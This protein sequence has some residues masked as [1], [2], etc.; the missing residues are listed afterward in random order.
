MASRLLL[1]I[2]LALA[3]LFA[4]SKPDVPI[5]DD[6]SYFLYRALYHF[7]KTAL[8]RDQGSIG[9]CVAVSHAGALDVE[10][11]VS[12]VKSGGGKFK[13]HSAESIYG[14][15]RN[16]AHGRASRSYA[17][18]SNGH[19][20]TRWLNQ[21]GGALYQEKYDGVDLSNYEVPRAKDWGATGNGGRSDGVNPL[22]PLDKEAA[23]NRV[24]G[25]AL[26]GDLEELDAA[27][28]H[29][30]PVTIC[31]GVGFNSPRDKDGFCAPRGSWPHC[32]FVVGKRNEGRKG[33]L[34][35]NSWGRYIRGDGENSTNKYKDQP[36]GS[37]YIEPSVMLRILRSGDSWALSINGFEGGEGTT[38][39]EWMLN[40][41]SVIPAYKM[42]EYVLTDYWEAVAESDALGKPLLVVFS[43]GDDSFLSH[44]IGEAGDDKAIIVKI[45][46][47]EEIKDHYGIHEKPEVIAHVRGR[48]LRI[49]ARSV[50]SISEVLR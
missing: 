37:F 15:A 10:E 26:V 13:K 50:D 2:L 39:P 35:Q 1:S 46:E 6:G 45:D 27:L 43:S 7:D 11:A 8:P 16:E 48:S 30:H 49:D 31:S 32:M 33:Y 44:V 4:G 22:G 25:V 20:A 29:G 5:N 9:T 12:L 34:I 36:D 47:N 23:K 14:G 3:A 24:K 18:G 41:D 21:V 42:E 38:L 19:E 28:K 17:D 40:P